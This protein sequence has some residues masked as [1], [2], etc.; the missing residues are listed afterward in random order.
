MSVRVVTDSTSDIPPQVAADL[1]VCIVPLMVLF[2]DEELRDGV[3]VTSEQ[4]F[5]R[6]M[7]EATTP[8][9]AQPSVGAFREVFEAL[10]AD[11]ATAIVSCHLSA[12]LSGT[13]ESARQAAEGLSV[14]VLLVDSGQVSLGLGVGVLQAAKAARDGATAQQVQAVAADVFR[15]TR[16]YIT[17]ETLEYLRRGGRL[18]RGQEL[19]GS[20]LK[21]KPILEIKDGE[22]EAVARIRTKQKAIEE[23]LSRCA[24][25]RPWQFAFAVHATTPQEVEYIADRFRGL[26]E[27]TPVMT[28]RMT[29]VLGVHAGL[30]GVGLGVVSAP[31]EASPPFLPT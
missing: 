27:E 31:D 16:T 6:L 20:L 30:G 13:Y 22:V 1:G 17:L 9:T 24:D 23:I 18:S 29:P 14:P 15:R 10:V 4:F 28:G 5:K 2:G 21:V 7:R 25:L 11:G 8:T 3:D 12:K 19:V 26:S